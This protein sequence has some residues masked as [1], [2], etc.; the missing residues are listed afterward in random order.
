MP[1]NKLSKADQEYLGETAENPFEAGVVSEPAEE[2]ASSDA[3][4]SNIDSAG[5]PNTGGADKVTI[6]DYSGDVYC[7]RADAAS[8]L[9]PM[10]NPIPWKV[11]PDTQ[12]IPTPDA[13]RPFPFFALARL[14]ESFFISNPQFLFA[15]DGVDRAV[16]LF[17][18]GMKNENAYL[19]FSSLDEK[20]ATLLPLPF[21]PLK[22]DLSP[23]GSILAGVREIAS[24]PFDKY[25]FFSLIRLTETQVKPV[26]Q[27][28]MKEPDKSRPGDSFPIIRWVSNDQFFAAEGDDSG[29]VILWELNGLNPIYSFQGNAKTLSL[30][31]NRKMFAVA[32]GNDKIEI[33]DTMS[34][35]PLGLIAA[36]NEGFAA[37]A[38]AFSPDG[39][40]LA[41]VFG[42]KA[43]I[44]R[45]SDGL[46]D[47]RFEKVSFPES[48]RLLWTDAESLLVG[49]RLYRRGCDIPLCDYSG[50]WRTFPFCF[51]QG[52]VWA[53]LEEAGTIGVIG[54]QLPHPE[55]VAAYGAIDR[56]EYFFGPGK[57]VRL[58]VSLGG[59]GDEAA[60][61]KFLTERLAAKEIAVS[62]SAPVTLEYSLKKSETQMEGKIR[63]Q[64]SVHRTRGRSA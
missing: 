55:A 44:Y 29:D 47:F 26:Y 10:V 6:P 3:R 22:S 46:E 38:T 31:P 7:A 48:S 1:E 43:V 60:A 59:F 36:E 63:R 34:G 61:K 2:P 37:S 42:D 21:C 28:I 16:L 54:Y 15:E 12:T 62:D 33:R 18:S 4:K 40:R 32:A 20:P 56:T 45:M 39:A 23:D 52:K 57:P 50:I 13:P 51:H 41:V 49:Q 14:K 8:S 35:A 27:F 19:A 53:V 58:L 64:F 5:T 17:N 11:K 25:R 9:P 30:S 24:G